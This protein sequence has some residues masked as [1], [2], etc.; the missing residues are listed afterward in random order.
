MHLSELLRLQLLSPSG[1]AVGK[2]DDVIVRLRGGDYPI[3]TGLVARVGSRPV[4]VPI[5]QVAELSEHRATLV[6]AKVDLRAF[7]RREG[8]VPL[9]EDILGHRLIDV[10]DA[11]LVRAWDV[12]LQ[13]SGEGLVVTC[14]DTRRPA[15]LFGLVRAGSGHPCKD[16]KVF[17]PLI[18]HT[19]DLGSAPP[20]PG[21][22]GPPGPPP[23]PARPES[24]PCAG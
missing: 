5:E 9:R 10:A 14:L 24:L 3:A 1:E 20:P 15:R 21:P 23:V 18:G 12:E 6:E 19:P 16:W 7:E 17:Q 22:A 13:A 4:F 11:E 8:E 2:I